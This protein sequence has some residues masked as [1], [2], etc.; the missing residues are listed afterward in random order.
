MF[1]FAHRVFLPAAVV[2]SIGVAACT[3]NA[4]PPGVPGPAISRPTTS[5]PTSDPD[6]SV[7]A[8][9]DVSPARPMP[10]PNGRPRPV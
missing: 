6:T 3:A 9:G 2:L 8:C 4:E 10:W 5:A 7:G 1:T